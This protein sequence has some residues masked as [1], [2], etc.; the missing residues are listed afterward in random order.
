MCVELAGVFLNMPLYRDSMRLYLVFECEL[1]FLQLPGFSIMVDQTQSSK[2]GFFF[3][4]RSFD[5]QK[6]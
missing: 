1:E 6:D 3:L 4:S 5:E 2:L